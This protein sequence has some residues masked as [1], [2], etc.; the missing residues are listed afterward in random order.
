MDGTCGHPLADVARTVLIYRFASISDR[1]VE[2]L[3]DSIIQEYLNAYIRLSNCTM[4]QIN[5]WELP[6]AATRLTESIPTEEK[7]RLLFR[8]DQ[9]IREDW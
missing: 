7:E 5:T 6:V 2:S 4:Q 1:V 9:L 8:I 3:R